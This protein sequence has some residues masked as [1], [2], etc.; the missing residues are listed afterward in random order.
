MIVTGARKTTT[1]PA[2]AKP[3]INKIKSIRA[4]NITVLVYLLRAIRRAADA[5]RPP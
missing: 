3:V 2:V 4:A 5:D 1:A